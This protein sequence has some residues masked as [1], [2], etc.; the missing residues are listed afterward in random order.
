MQQVRYTITKYKNK[1]MSYTLDNATNQLDS[2]NFTNEDADINSIGNIYV[3]KVMNVVK[4]LNAAFIEYLPNGV[5]GYLPLNFEQTPV[6]I[7]RKY[8]GRIIA[9]DEILVQLEKEAVRTKEPVFTTNLSLAGKYCVITTGNTY[10]GISKKCGKVERTILKAALPSESPYGIV[11]RTNAVEQINNIDIVKDECSKLISEMDRIIQFGKHRTCFS[12]VWKSPVAYLTF[13][14]DSNYYE[15]TKITTDDETI[16]SQLKEFLE[17]N[18]PELIPKLELYNDAS[19]PISKLHSIQTKIDEVLGKKV[20]LKSGAYLVIEKTEALYVIDVNSGKNVPK[21][22][23]DNYM[24]SINLESAQEIMRQI[25]LRN[26]SG[27][28]LVD[29]IN[30]PSQELN[31]KLLSE[32]RI[33]AKKDKVTTTIVDMTPLGLIEITRKKIQKSLQEQIL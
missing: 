1:I 8:D 23:N 21:K 5:K 4:N 7:N 25:R 31:D 17:L 32:L 10:K 2:I 24:Y 16:Y 19:Y 11:I 12:C 18:Q 15:Y 13:I 22:L 33:M 9:G 30:M 14:R 20:W 27:M 29:F 26:L 6:L 28:I 3:A